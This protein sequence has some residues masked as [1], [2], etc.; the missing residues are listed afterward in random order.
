MTVLAHL[1]TL[2]SLALGYAPGSR[3]VGSERGD[4]YSFNI[5]PVEPAKTFLAMYVIAVRQKYLFSYLL[6]H[7]FYYQVL[8]L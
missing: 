8:K 4:T 1:C 6:A 5:L 7:P 3:V 2:L